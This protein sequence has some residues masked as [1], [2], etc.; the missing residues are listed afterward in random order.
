MKFGRV[1][2]SRSKMA[3]HT[4]CARAVCHKMTDLALTVTLPWVQQ[5]SRVYTVSVHHMCVYAEPLVT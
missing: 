1:T 2:P 4:S 3:V 5:A